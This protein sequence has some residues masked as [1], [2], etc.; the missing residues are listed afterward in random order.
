MPL[1]INH[2]HTHTHTHTHPHTH[3]Q[4]HTHTRMHIHTQ[5]THTYQCVNQNNF[6]KL[7][8]HDLRTCSWFKNDEMPRIVK[9]H[10]TIS[11]K[12]HTII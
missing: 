6:K 3:T 10:W 9:A 7:G 5:H 8:T 2:T 12:D 4:T 11:T 1:V